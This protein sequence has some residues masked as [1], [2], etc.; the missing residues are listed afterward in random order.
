MY[1]AWPAWLWRGANTRSLFRQQRGHTMQ[2]AIGKRLA[3][4]HIRATFTASFTLF[5]LLPQATFEDLAT[6]LLRL[7]E[8]HVG[9]LVGLE[10]TNHA[11]HVGAAT[12]AT[13]EARR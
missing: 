1:I 10:I 13:W 4:N 6:R 11:T 3:P 9:K 12:D 7:N 8:H 5:D 2:R